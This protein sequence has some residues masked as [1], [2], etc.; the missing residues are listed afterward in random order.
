MGILS[1]FSNLEAAE[2][3]ALFCLEI[4]TYLHSFLGFFLRSLHYLSNMHKNHIGR[5]FICPIDQ[6][7]TLLWYLTIVSAENTIID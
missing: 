4:R 5:H 1:S 7:D 3:L 6:Q 2:V